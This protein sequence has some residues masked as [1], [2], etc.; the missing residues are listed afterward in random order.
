MTLAW[1]SYDAVCAVGRIFEVCVTSIDRTAYPTF[2]R[3]DV[4]RPALAGMAR[5][6]E[7]PAAAAIDHSRFGYARLA[8][9]RLNAIACAW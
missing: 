5:S 8:L 3:I 6:A 2:K 4:A 1:D 7:K 9:S